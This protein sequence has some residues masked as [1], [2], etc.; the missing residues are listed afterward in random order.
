MNLPEGTRTY[1]IID[2]VKNYRSELGI[3]YINEF[4]RKVL[5]KLFKENGLVPSIPCSR[6]APYIL[7]M[8][9][10]L[11]WFIESV[12]IQELELY[13]FLVLNRG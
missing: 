13:P 3:L 9:P 7:S 8:S 12:S 10:D 5:E 4:N 11:P 1:E 6:P 2:D